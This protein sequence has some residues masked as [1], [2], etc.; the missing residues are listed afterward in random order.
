MPKEA[1][2]SINKDLSLSSPYWFSIPPD[3]SGSGKRKRLYFKTKALA[4]AE[5]ERIRARKD[6]F[7]TSLSSLSGAHIAE[8]ANCYRILE[9]TCPGVALLE[10]VREYC[11]IYAKRKKSISVKELFDR[12]VENRR[13]YGTTP[14][15]VKRL[16][17]SL[18]KFAP[19]HS[20]LVC[21]LSTQDLEPLLRG[22]S[23]GSQWNYLGS[24]RAA[25]NY[26]VKMD[27]AA[28]NPALKIERISPERMETEIFSPD[29][30]RQLLVYTLLNRLEYLPH[31]IFAFFCGIRAYGELLRLDWSAVSIKDRMLTLKAA[32]TKTKRTRFIPIPEN[33]AAWLESYKQ[34]GGSVEGLVVKINRDQH[35]RWNR[36]DSRAVGIPKWIHSGAR[37]SFCSYWMA[38]NNNDVDKLVVISGHSS[39][40]VMW[41][42]YYRATTEEA[43][44]EYFSIMP[45]DYARANIVSFA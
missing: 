40:D 43:A 10:A 28:T 41:R 8:A 20:K 35:L 16:K 12:F 14:D 29:Q 5:R 23:P 25:L 9:E 27:Y 45:P 17:W 15:H 24:L 34:L 22:V 30:V 13:D 33:A 36:A 11:S 32:I 37:H 7:G 26:A 4:E 21:D 31:R 44:K 1:S 3:L 2:L 42:H 39:K 19:L 18:N 38:A 6:N